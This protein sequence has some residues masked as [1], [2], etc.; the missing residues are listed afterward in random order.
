MHA[1]HPTLAPSDALLRRLLTPLLA[2]A[3]LLASWH[4]G[5]PT[6]RPLDAAPGQFSA[7]RAL[8]PLRTLAR[9]PHPIGSA[10]HAQ[11]HE[12]LLGQL[13]AL[14]L[15]PEL[16]E[17]WGVLPL[18]NRLRGAAGLVRN[19]LVRV[20][21][22]QGSGKALLIS[23]HYDSVHT[24][25]GAGDDGA[26]VAAVLEAL[27]ALREGPPLQ[28]DLIVLF[29]DGEEQGLLGAEAFAAE[30]RWRHD[31]GLALNFEY[32]GNRGPISM[33]ETSGDNGLLIEGL[34]RAVP[35][36]LA[37][38]LMFEIYKRLPNDTDLSSF[39]R[40]GWAGMNF[41]AIEGHTAYHA[42]VDT[43]EAMD[44]GTLQQ[45]GDILLALLRHFGQQT[46]D[47]L[48]APD[49]VY[50][51]FPG[52]P[53]LHYGQATMQLLSTVCGLALLG[54]AWRSRREW[55]FGRLLGGLATSV[56]STA[57]AG[58]LAYG[59]WQLVLTLHPHYRAIPSGATYN[60][61]PYALAW[62]VLTVLGLAQ[63]QRALTRWLPPLEQTLGAALLWAALLLAC[64]LALPGASFLFLLPLLPLAVALNAPAAWRALA[65]GLAALPGLMLLA[66]LLRSL[67]IGLTVRDGHLMVILL[68]L[69]LALQAAWLGPWLASRTL[70][71]SL[72]AVAVGALGWATAQSGFT[73]ERPQPSTLF[74]AQLGSD[75]PALWLSDD[76]PLPAWSQP[77]FKTGAQRAVPEL[78][79][80]GA[81]PL[82]AAPGPV[83][84]GMA[85]PVIELLGDRV[86]G[87]QRQLEL[88]LRSPR[89]AP[90]LVLN[91]E[92]ASVLASRLQGRVYSLQPSD[93]WGISLFAVPADGVAMTLTLPAGRP[94]TLRLRDRQWGLPA[95]SHPPRGP[96]LMPKPFGATDT[97]QAVTLRAFEAQPSVR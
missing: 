34:A 56:L 57:I 44:L 67:L 26:S 41:A 1:P 58:V 97:H 24:G 79:G 45:Q 29:S 31:I 89:G 11:V 92:G 76:E 83:Q 87:Q 71:W 63:L 37:T 65:C 28:R 74:L 14:G 96:A 8:Q 73:A 22:T 7:Q 82:W 69:W 61:M 80:P 49:R 30:H 59:A 78:L 46:L 52:L 94:F 47:S 62:A 12:Y 51:D 20:P 84:A 91:V 32:R 40:A 72:L 75:G 16:Q 9:A 64:T 25:P 33:F 55:R 4:V 5:A 88:R 53:L 85:M 90:S 10:E 18:G 48:R 6:P 70:R 23:A 81:K 68:S 19:V 66:P 42:A 17:S 54:A 93:N 77:L 95:G 35:Q 3:L 50:F 21:G 43:P 15:Q 2:V 27:R 86:D 60:D 36:A 13:R 39:K 38:S